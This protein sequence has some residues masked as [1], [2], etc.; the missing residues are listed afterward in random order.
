M[1]ALKLLLATSLLVTASS[2][3]F[4]QTV[5]HIGGS[6]A[7]R[8]A[9]HNAIVH[10][11][12]ANGGTCHVAFAGTSGL[13]GANQA[14]FQGTV[15]GLS[16]T[17][18]VETA[19]NGSITGVAGLVASN[20]FTFLTAA[21]ISTTSP[22][23]ATASTQAPSNGTSVFSNF[24]VTP[25]PTLTS[26]AQGTT[27]VTETVVPDIALSD[28]FQSSTPFASSNGF[29][30]LN[31]TEVGVIPFTWLKG[32]AV[33]TD[34]D[35]VNGGYGRLTNI[36]ALQ[37]KFLFGQGFVKA[38]GLTG[39]P[40]DAYFINLVGRDYDSGTRFD[41]LAE[42]Q[43]PGT[44]T[45]T[46]FGN[47]AIAVTGSGAG[48]V[49]VDNSNVQTSS[50]LSTKLPA[51]G[52]YNSGGKLVAALQATGTDASNDFGGYLVTYAG[53]SDA[54]TVLGVTAGGPTGYSPVATLSF[55]GVNLT[56]ANVQN[57][58]YSFWTYEHFL[59]KP[60]V[61]GAVATFAPILS[62][63][64]ISTDATVAGYKLSDLPAAVK[65]TVEGGTISLQ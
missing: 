46:Q 60:G 51:S 57:G 63:Q 62:G 26:G 23:V 43:S 3:A 1:K 48:S 34:T 50:T 32:G 29:A 45:I 20:Q 56:K 4:A 53:A 27:S 37:A 12:T 19:W 44:S 10:L 58:T 38:Q 52:G 31:D 25:G 40:A 14:V 39:N 2:S 17:T 21:N 24:G 59:T 33:S 22:G 35:V 30:A 49:I 28:A 8:S 6:T 54:D 42:A 11:M 64:L 16:G 61:T 36:T 55:N 65:R 15:A 5:I 13:A 41:A 7:Y 47:T 18:T 9:V